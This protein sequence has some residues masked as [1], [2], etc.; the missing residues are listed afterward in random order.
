MREPTDNRRGAGDNGSLRPGGSSAQA[1]IERKSAPPNLSASRGGVGRE[2]WA[3]NAVHTLALT[4]ALYVI[5]CAGKPTLGLK[6]GKPAPMDAYARVAFQTVDLEATKLARELARRDSPL[7]FHATKDSFKASANALISAIDTGRNSPL[8]SQ[9]KNEEDR[10]S[11]LEAL[12][13]FRRY[14]PA[15]REALARLAESVVVE[16]A[17]AGQHRIKPGSMVVVQDPV[18]HTERLVPESEVVLLSAESGHFAQAFARVLAGVPETRRASVLAALAVLLKPTVKLNQEE[19]EARADA[20]AQAQQ[21]VLKYIEKGTLLVAKGAE[22]TH[23]NILDMMAE[24]DSYNK[25][26]AGRR[27]HLYRLIGLAVALLVVVG[28]GL[29]YVVQ[30]RPE[31]LAPPL[32]GL[33]RVAFSLLTL[34]LVAVARLFTVLD[35]SL[36]LA[37][38]PLVVMVLCLVYDQ[39]FGFAMAALCALLV[40]LAQGPANMDFVVL[41]LGG[42]MAA[43]MTR[44]VRT[45][46]TL[47]QVGLLTGL[48]QWA[49]AWGIGMLTTRGDGLPVRFW[50]SPLLMNSCYAL[51]NGILSGFLLSGLLPAIER[52]FGVTTDIRLLEWSNPNQPLLQRLLVEAPGTY[53]HSMLV[54]N[55]AAEAAEAIGANPLLARVSGYFHDVGKI[56]KPEYFV[57]N[58]PKDQKSPHEELTPLMSRLIITAHPRDGA[59]LAAQHGLPREVQDIILESHGSTTVKY[60]WDRAQEQNGGQEKPEESAFRYRLPKPRSKEAV[61][62]MLADSAESASRALESPS[63]ARIAETTHQIV[64]DR[65]LDGQLNESGITLTDLERIE[66]SLIRG[67]NAVYHKRIAYPAQ[68]ETEDQKEEN[69]HPP[70][71]RKN[72]QTDDRGGESPE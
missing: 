3:A 34:L 4:A 25:S 23:Q 24:R 62:V 67:L 49:A 59:D 71:E 57:E 63:P 6:L 35:V 26:A 41:M 13:V 56:K 69:E 72:G 20:A 65:L 48:V 1:G 30:Y 42:M 68:D 70:A 12:P 64:M 43:L 11:I 40:G 9:L 50:E 16:P 8:W 29:F 27:L 38:L 55:L 47:I 15:L 61:C 22:V 33:Q 2:G 32:V 14:E 52:L 44:R 36:L 19:T 37:P 58:M 7:V 39:R 5:L 53:H 46:S 28:T 45:R 51:L 17:D 66:K 21:H 60:F 10:R 31:L 54:A 18:E